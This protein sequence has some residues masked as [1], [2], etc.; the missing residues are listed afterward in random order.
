MFA[1]SF[2]LFSWCSLPSFEPQEYLI[3][4]FVLIACSNLVI[5]QWGLV[6]RSG[7]GFFQNGRRCIVGSCSNNQGHRRRNVRLLWHISHGVFWP[8]LARK[9]IG[10]SM[11]TPLTM[12]Y[13]HIKPL[14]IFNPTGFLKSGVLLSIS[15]FCSQTKK[16]FSR[17]VVNSLVVHIGVK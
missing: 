1:G 3:Q 7:R 15:T 9:T 12:L 17:R 6:A 8:R 13:F 11:Q 14:K 2:Y 5:P 4:M 16:Q 10:V